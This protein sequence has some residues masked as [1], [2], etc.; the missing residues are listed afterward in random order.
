MWEDWDGEEGRG[1]A[2]TVTTGQWES[3]EKYKKKYKK[4]YFINVRK[5]QGEH[6][7]AAMCVRVPRTEERMKHVFFRQVFFGRCRG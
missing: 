1:I 3:R 6:V 7:P 5:G 4:M 2:E